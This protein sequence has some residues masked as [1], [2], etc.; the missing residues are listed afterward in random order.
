MVLLTRLA[1]LN[2][3]EFDIPDDIY[4][5]RLISLIINKRLTVLK[6]KSVYFEMC[7]TSFHRYELY[8]SIVIS[9]NK[10]MKDTIFNELQKILSIEINNKEIEYHEQNNF[11]NKEE[12]YKEKLTVLYNQ[13][14]F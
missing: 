11:N 8:F 5:I 1:L 14:N 3:K 6:D 13:E 9:S 2:I 10:T 7:Y 12:L 4:Y